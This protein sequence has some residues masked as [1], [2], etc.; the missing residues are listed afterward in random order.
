MGGDH[1]RYP[2]SIDV[3]VSADVTHTTGTATAAPA[4][5]GALLPVG[6]DRE[7]MAGRGPFRAWS[8]LLWALAEII[9]ASVAGILRHRWP[10]SVLV[11]AVIA[12]GC[13][14]VTLGTM[15]CAWRV[16]AGR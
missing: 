4:L 14:A 6:A 10:S 11:F 5:A 15:R 16:M 1:A 13:I 9:W 3:P 8:L 2:D 12:G 7:R